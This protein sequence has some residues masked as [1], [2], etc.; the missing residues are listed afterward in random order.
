MS[1]KKSNA[2]GVGIVEPGIVEPMASREDEEQMDVCFS[3]GEAS[4][5][6]IH[7]R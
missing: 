7:F 3:F 5:H 6:L 1:R 4:K 2:S